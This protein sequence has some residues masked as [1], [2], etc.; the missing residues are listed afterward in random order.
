[1]RLDRLSSWFDE[2]FSRRETSAADAD[3]PVLVAFGSQTGGAIQL[4]WATAKALQSAGVKARVLPLGRV[5]AADLQGTGKALFIASTYGDGEPPDNAAA[6]D[7]R[8]MRESLPLRSLGYGLLALGDRQYADFCAF[9]RRLDA[10]LQAQGALPLFARIEADGDDDAALHAWQQGLSRLAGP[11]VLAG[12]R[13]PGF[14]P[15]RLLRRDWLNRGS[16]GGPTF[17]LEL[18]PAHGPLPHWEAGDLAQ[19][20]VP[21]DERRPREYSIASIPQ[22]GRLHLLVRLERGDG[23]TPGLASGWLAE[24]LPLQETLPLRVRANATFRLGD[25]AGRPLILIGNG[26]GLAGLLSLLKARIAGGQRRHWLLFGERHR[27]S[28]FYHR[29]RIESWVRA[30]CIE[31][32]NLAF[33]RDQPERIYV[34]HL[35]ARQADRLRGWIADGA[36]VYVCGSLKGMAGEVDAVLRQVLGDEGVQ[37]LAAE[38]RYRRDVY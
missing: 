12:W 24:Q 4:A 25:N 6:F 9:G 16:S 17:H 31:R 15:W 20:R 7:R 18:A 35:L 14:E 37:A 29:D 34:Q 22:D 30:G 19:V 5:E 36:A 11:A 28:D 33:S 23:G 8:W 27:A 26:T 3:A 21:G 1:M 13:T 2:L 32:L 10:W 38:G